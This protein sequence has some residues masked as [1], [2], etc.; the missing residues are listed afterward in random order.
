M[1]QKQAV[2]LIILAVI[3]RH[4]L[5]DDSALSALIKHMIGD[6]ARE[7]NQLGVSSPD[8][9]TILEQLDHLRSLQ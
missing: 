6:V 5:G 2:L 4:Q 8:L 3:V 7:L 1:T 9:E